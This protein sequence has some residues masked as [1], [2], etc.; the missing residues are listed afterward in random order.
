MIT[1]IRVF[2]WFLDYVP[3]PPSCRSGVS[4]RRDLRARGSVKWITSQCGQQ[5]RR[6][7]GAMGE[8]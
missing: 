1:N 7:V 3:K 5:R 2:S 8:L 4:R 6:A